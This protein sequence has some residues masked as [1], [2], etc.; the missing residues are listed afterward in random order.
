MSLYETMFSQFNITV[1]QVLVTS[2]DFNT[3]ERRRM[4]KK[5]LSDLLSVGIVPLLNEID[6]V[7]G[8]EGY[9]TFDEAFSDN[10]SLASLVAIEISAPLLI[11]LTDVKGVYDRP[12]TEPEAQIIDVF[13]Q[14]TE[15]VEGSKSLQGRGGMGAKVDAALKAV[16]GG[17]QA[18]VIGAGHDPETIGRAIAGEKVGTLFLHNVSSMSSPYASSANLPTLIGNPVEDLTALAEQCRISSRILAS[19]SG[20]VRKQILLRISSKLI[21]NAEKILEVNR[22]EIIEAEKT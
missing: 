13:Q 14:Q 10:D 3:P 6:A 7:S 9:K 1:S 18:V 22:E 2:L 20:E 21:E 4:V 19:S 12:P 5:T 8:N 17:V 15:F 16:N 11:L